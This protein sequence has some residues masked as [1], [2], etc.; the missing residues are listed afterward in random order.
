M[1]AITA[2]GRGSTGRLLRRHAWTAGTWVLLAALV[3]WY[4]ILIPRFG[5]FE[6]SAILRSGLPLAFLALA[7][8]II[9]ISGGIDL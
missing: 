9:V 5:G 6:V 8:G 2:A 4:A 7:Q 1:T 3:V